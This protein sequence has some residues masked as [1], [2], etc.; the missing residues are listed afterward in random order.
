MYYNV[1]SYGNY[2]WIC[3]KCQIEA[4]TAGY[5]VKVNAPW[6]ASCDCDLNRTV[7]VDYTTPNS[8][9]DYYTIDYGSDWGTVNNG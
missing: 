1:N 9:P 8:M 2:G 6:V 4:D 5:S 3:P 7:W